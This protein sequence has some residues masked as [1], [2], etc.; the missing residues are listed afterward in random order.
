MRKKHCSW[1]RNFN[2]HS[3][4]GSDVDDANGSAVVLNFNPH[5]RE[6]SDADFSDGEASQTDF[7]PHSREGSDS[8]G[9]AF[10]RL[11][12]ISIHTPAKG[13]TAPAPTETVYTSISIHTPAKGVTDYQETASGSPVFQSTLP[14]R[15]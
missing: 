1:Q 8:A 11:S 5:S 15:E 3:R 2:P 13:V 9:V 7:N 14:R 12:G 6:G 4:E 10:G